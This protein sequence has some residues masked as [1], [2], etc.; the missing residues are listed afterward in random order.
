MARKGQKPGRQKVRMHLRMVPV[1]RYI[2][3][4]FILF[5]VWFWV[6]IQKSW[7]GHVIYI[8][9]TWKAYDQE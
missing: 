4:S 9:A 3:L 1:S 6:T 8:R 5:L 2:F 7:S